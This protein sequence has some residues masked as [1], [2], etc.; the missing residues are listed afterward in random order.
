MR[1]VDQNT[2]HK[3]STGTSQGGFPFHYQAQNLSKPVYSKKG[4]KP[5]E[6]SSKNVQNMN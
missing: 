2:Y 4:T 1:D 6:I 5:V 3:S